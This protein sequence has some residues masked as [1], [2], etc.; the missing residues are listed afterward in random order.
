M[1]RVSPGEFLVQ[2][3]LEMNPLTLPLYL[4]GLAV[5]LPGS[6]LR[7]WRVLPIAFLVVAGMLI[8]TGTSKAYYLAAGYPLLAAPGA[9][10]AESAMRRGWRPVV[11]GVYTGL[12]AVSGC[13]LAPFAI[14]ILSPEDYL[15]YS[16]ALGITPKAEERNTLGSLP[17]H[18]ADMFGWSELVDSVHAV[19]MSLTPEEQA[20]CVVYGQNY[21]EAGAIDVLGRRAGL[22]RAISGHNSYW[23]WGPGDWS[24]KV[25]IVIGGRREDLEENFDSVEAAGM[26]ACRYCMPY[27]NGRT[28]WIVRGLRGEAA[29]LWPET[30][31]FI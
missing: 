20:A 13:L 12:L 21:G 10:I 7:I 8:A 27:E 17:Q 11:L 31:M 14:P 24:G 2:Q 4:A 29:A 22:P 1:V 18:F 9:V 28:I 6:S 30:R 5:F 16:Q 19:Y 25:M 26:T 23:F 15:S 3:M